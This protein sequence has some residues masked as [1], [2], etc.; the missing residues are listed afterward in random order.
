MKNSP[1]I[2]FES[3]AIW[4][5]APKMVQNA[6][7][8]SWILPR[9]A[10]FLDWVSRFMLCVK[11]KRNVSFEFWPQNW[12]SIFFNSDFLGACE[13]SNIF[14]LKNRILN[15]VYHRVGPNWKSCENKSHDTFWVISNQCV[16]LLDANKSLVF[17]V[18]M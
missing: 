13:S 9:F 12:L 18:L 6:T 17:K 15:T 4:I 7:V 1:N 10:D 16:K 3:K 11:M 5:F 2:I 14:T 8:K